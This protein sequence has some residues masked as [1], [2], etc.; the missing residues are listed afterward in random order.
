[1]VIHLNHS[2]CVTLVRAFCLIVKNNL[3]KS[4]F[5]ID[6]A[7]KN[8]Q[9][10]NQHINRVPTGYHG[11]RSIVI[12]A[13]YFLSCLT[14]AEPGRHGIRDDETIRRRSS[15]DAEDPVSPRLVLDLPPDEL[16]PLRGAAITPEATAVKR[17]RQDGDHAGDDVDCMEGAGSDPTVGDFKRRG[18]LPD[19]RVRDRERE[20]EVTTPSPAPTL[21]SSF[22]DAGC[23][24][25]SPGSAPSSTPGPPLFSVPGRQMTPP[26]GT[27]SG[28]GVAGSGGGACHKY[29]HSMM[30]VSFSRQRFLQ[31]KK[32]HQK[33]Y[34]T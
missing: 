26:V 1:M 16:S 23:S 21:T 8:S 18:Q 2:R 4:L 28:G 11:P 30:Q 19:R 5:L 25:T 34:K 12:F 32:N 10:V 6:R 14:D 29:K 22:S 20:R 24:V 7:C 31:P 17:K 15:G 3:M 9:S 13:L 33:P 27:S